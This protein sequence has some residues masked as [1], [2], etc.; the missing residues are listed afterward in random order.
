MELYNNDF[1]DLSNT[2]INVKIKEIKIEYDFLKEEIIK[3]CDKLEILEKVYN[4]GK[5]ELKKR[6]IE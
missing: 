1:N 6:G 2:S 3:I 5:E 4:K